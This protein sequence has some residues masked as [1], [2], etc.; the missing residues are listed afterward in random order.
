[1]KLG[2]QHVHSSKRGAFEGFLLSSIIIQQHWQSSSSNLQLADIE[3]T[4][5]DPPG[6]G[7]HSVRRQHTAAPPTTASSFIKRRNALSCA[8]VP[9]APGWNDTAT[10]FGNSTR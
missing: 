1:V 6:D 2:S 9:M 5:R 7:L 4:V 3:V 8:S 10:E